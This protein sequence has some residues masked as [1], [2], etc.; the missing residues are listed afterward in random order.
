MSRLIVEVTRGSEV[1][2][3][4]EVIALQLDANGKRQ[5]IFGSAEEWSRPI[6]PRSAIKPL[7]ALA[8]VESGGIEKLKLRPAHL[9]LACASHNGERIHRELAT[10]WLKILGLSESYLKCGAHWP[11]SNEAMR[12]E[13]RV[14]LQPSALTNNCSGKHLG[15]L[16]ACQVQGWDL[17]TYKQWD[18]PL[19]KKI[20]AIVSSLAEVNLERVPWGVDGCG[21]PTLAMGLDLWTKAMAIFL[22]TAVGPSQIWE[23]VAR[24]PELIGGAADF[25]TK[26][27]RDLNG[28]VLLKN[29][30][31]GV[32]LIADRKHGFLLGIKA[33]DG[34]ARAR[35]AVTG[36]LLGR[37]SELQDSGPTEIKNWNGEVTGEIRVTELST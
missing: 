26:I 34:A 2:S 24:N 30:A 19:Q 28:A 37:W 25:N 11:S 33:L 21:I 27:L 35:D 13:A 15:F 12:E 8:L 6:F 29:G 9:A 3:R 32:A 7:Q 4:H 10:D 16:T 31:E 5:A 14:H 22:T 18:H 36:F 1:E 23:A 20:R 17:E